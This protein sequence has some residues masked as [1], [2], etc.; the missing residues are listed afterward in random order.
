MTQTTL[1]QEPPGINRLCQLAV[2][3]PVA[4]GDIAWS[5]L[6]EDLSSLP[7]ETEI[8]FVS[9]ELP[10]DLLKHLLDRLGSGRNLRWLQTLQGRAL[11]LNAGVKATQKPY[12][13]FLHADS[14][15]DP[16]ALEGLAE[17][18]ERQPNAL[19]Y[20]NLAFLD[21]GPS[22]TVLN[23]LGVWVRSHCFGMPFG[24]QGFC[25]PRQ[26]FETLN[27]FREDASYGED[28]LLVW[29]A[30]SQGVPLHC[31]G[32][33]V[34]TSARKYRE[35]GWWRT[36]RNHLILTAKQAFPEWLTLLKSRALGFL[37]QL[38]NLW[39]NTIPRLKRGS[40]RGAK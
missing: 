8:I 37:S 38:D 4:P 7:L 28:H 16:S 12:L 40:K 3:V 36:T 9:P 15:F 5:R 2:V 24:D 29:Q 20:F 19:H 13:W 23:A 17:S 11:Q 25:L 33:T 30:R 22:L 1:L 26:L 18:L 34:Q 10:L 39:R 32:K 31:T 27:G 21:D 14:R 35:N 6:A